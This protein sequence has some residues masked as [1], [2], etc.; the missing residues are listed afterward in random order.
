MNPLLPIKEFSEMCG[1]TVSTLR[2][3]D[4]L[5][6]LS[7]ARRNGD[8]RY[9]Y[10]SPNQVMTAG[11]LESLVKL[12]I[13]LKTFA[14]AYRETAPECFLG[15]FRDCDRRFETEIAKLYAMKAILRNYAS[16]MEESQSIEPGNI[17]VRPLPERPVHFVSLENT[18]EYDLRQHLTQAGYNS[19]PSG[20]VFSSPAQAAGPARAACIFRPGR[21]RNPPGRRLPDRHGDMPLRRDGQPD[22]PHVRLCP[23]KWPETARPCVYGLPAGYSWHCRAGGQFAANLYGGKACGGWGIKQDITGED[24]ER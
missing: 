9:R 8:T 23:P 14:E 22:S 2:Y 5:G 15:L 18:D 3:W 19:S 16:L 24:F 20:Y 12:D 11:L 7:P 10:Y 13:P 6:L 21:A 17:G 4:E 1:V